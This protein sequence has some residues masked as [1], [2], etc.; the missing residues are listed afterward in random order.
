[1]AV[2][3]KSLTG[4]IAVSLFALAACTGGSGGSSSAADAAVDG[5]ADSAADIGAPADVPAADVASELGPADGEADLVV[6]A[7]PWPTDECADQLVGT[8]TGVGDI[9]PNFTMMSQHGTEVS[10]HDYC[11]R[12]VLL[13]GS[14]FWCE[15]CREEAPTLEPLYQEHKDQGLMI[16]TLLIENY[17]GEPPDQQ[18]LNTWADEYAQTFPVLSDAQTQIHAYSAKGKDTV[19]LPMDILIGPG[20]EVLVV[21]DTVNLE[22]VLAALP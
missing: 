18:D 22:D 3:P 20:A 12:A 2:N 5:A 9:A 4:W 15:G 13:V 11:D 7:N 17:D 10:L 1:M 14:A 19:K 6:P 8:G 16:M 21:M